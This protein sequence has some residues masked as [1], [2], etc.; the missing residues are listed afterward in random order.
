MAQSFYAQSSVALSES[1]RK[2]GLNGLTAPTFPSHRCGQTTNTG[3]LQ[4]VII[5]QFTLRYVSRVSV[6]SCVL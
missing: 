4:T 1:Q 2:C 6:E 5:L 3:E